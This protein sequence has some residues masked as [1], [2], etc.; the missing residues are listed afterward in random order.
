MASILSGVGCRRT[1]NSVPIWGKHGGGTGE[2]NLGK[3]VL[4]PAELLDREK[5]LNSYFLDMGLNADVLMPARNSDG[6]SSAFACRGLR[7]L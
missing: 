2:M 4:C 1:A 7:G 5:T 3:P 6:S